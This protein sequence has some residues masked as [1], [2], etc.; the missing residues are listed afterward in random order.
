MRN[1][2]PADHM[3]LFLAFGLMANAGVINSTFEV[4]VSGACY[5]TTIRSE[6]RLDL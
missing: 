4:P 5:V 3:V 1:I 6:R 2:R